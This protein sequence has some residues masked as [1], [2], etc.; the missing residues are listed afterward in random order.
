MK[1]KKTY[2]FDEIEKTLQ[3]P[4]S[5]WAVLTVLPFVR[6]I[7]YIFANYTEI[8]PNII[9]T[10][11]LLLAFV[12]TYFFQKGDYIFLVLGAV[13]Y[14]LSY[15]FDCTDGTIA[16]LKRNGSSFGKIYDEFT[17]SLKIFI[18]TFGL[19][20]GQYKIN[21]MDS[22]YLHAGYLFLGVM[23]LHYERL[24]LR[25]LTFSDFKVIKISSKNK[26][27]SIINKYFKY[28]EN[29]KLK[30]IPSGIE[31]LAFIYVIVPIAAP[32]LIIEST[33]LA[34]CYLVLT[35]MQQMVSYYKTNS[36][37]NKK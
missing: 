26:P 36:Q 21:G 15:I 12:S 24:I 28:M 22:T 16:R 25:D 18:I 8:T 2:T 3:T 23:L 32:S 6:K 29:H 35:A 34:S 14:Q 37:K 13:F 10:I 20:Y 11:S 5:W 4:K 17:D 30:A 27:R 19:F 33:I 31:V 1:Q 9:T 7:S